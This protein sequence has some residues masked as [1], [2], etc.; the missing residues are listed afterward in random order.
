MS[1]LK[2]LLDEYWE[3]RDLV[4]PN[5]WESLGWAHTELGEVY[6]ILLADGDWVRNNPE[7]HPNAFDNEHFAEELGDVIMMIQKAGMV[8]GVDPLQALYNKI[9]KKMKNG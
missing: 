4:H 1:K 2:T 3:F 7:D 5:V 8:R 6:E 9:E